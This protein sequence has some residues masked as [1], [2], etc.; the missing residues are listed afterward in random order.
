MK[1][2]MIGKYIAILGLLLF[3]APLWGLADTYFIM[4]SSFQEITLFGANDTK[5]PRDEMSSAALS[6]ALGF[7]LCLVALILLAVSVVGLNYRTSWLFWALVV[8]SILLLFMKPIG[9]L[10]GLIVL[11]LLVLNRKKFGLVNDI[12]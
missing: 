3:W 7:L 12:T 2:E 1:K 6:T 9:T 10:F 5:I 4:S 8:Y 11:V